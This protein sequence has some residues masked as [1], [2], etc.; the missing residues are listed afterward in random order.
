MACECDDGIKTSCPASL[1]PM[2]GPCCCD[3]DCFNHEM[4]SN[5]DTSLTSNCKQIID[6]KGIIRIICENQ[7]MPTICPSGEDLSTMKAKCIENK[8]NPII[9]IDPRGCEFIDCR[10]DNYQNGSMFQNTQ[11]P[12]DADL[13]SALE[14]CKALGF[15]PKVY[16]DHGCKFINCAQESDIY[17][18]ETLNK[19]DIENLNCESKGL[20]LGKDYDSKG[21]PFYTCFEANYCRTEMPDEAV[22]KCKEFG[23]EMTMQ[24]DAQGCI[25]FFKCVQRGQSDQAY[26]KPVEE[27][28]DATKLMQVALGLDTLVMKLDEL[29]RKTSSIA[30]YYASLGSDEEAR[31][32]RVSGMFK[33]VIEKVN[34]IKSGI[35]ENLRGMT[36]EYLEQVKQDIKYIKDVVLMDIVY[37]MLSSGEDY[38]LN[39]TMPEIICDSDECF[40]KYFR[41][42]QPTKL[43]LQD[44]FEIT[45]TGL[46]NYSCVAKVTLPE[47]KAPEIPGISPPYEMTCKKSDYALGFN[48][49]EDVTKYCEGNLVQI[50]E[51]KESDSE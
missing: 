50:I 9:K 32:R 26:I 42:C 24:K 10:F 1:D 17:C 19:T 16:F 8:G 48:T 2:G 35:R 21:C 11:C 6:E 27:V 3:A 18:P 44:G 34:S 20:V 14:K 31:F 29:A 23:G 46:E 47:D 36:I 45:I 41:I 12:T 28:P 49:K 51:L 15:E 37:V 13:N 30:D 25:S 7:A 22:T 4:C 40:N 43:K 38:E 33:G 5:S 39:E